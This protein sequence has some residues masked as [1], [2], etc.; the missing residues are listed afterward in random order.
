MCFGAFHEREQG[1][2]SW[3]PEIWVWFNIILVSVIGTLPQDVVI[4]S[5]I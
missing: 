5:T 4:V 1:I 2:F 3:K